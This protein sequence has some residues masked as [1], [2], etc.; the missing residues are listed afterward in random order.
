YVERLKNDFKV[1]TIDIRGN[2]ESDKPIDPAYYTTEK[3]CQDILTV[4]S[5]C[6]LERFIIWGYSYG[7]NIGR[8]FAA[9]S[10]CVSKFVM[11]GFTFGPG[12]SGPFRR[13]I[14]DFSDHWFPILRAQ[15]D[16]SLDLQS[17]SAKDQSLLCRG[18]IPV[19]LAWLSQIL[20]WEAIE[21]GDLLCPTLWF[22]GS[23]N[24][25]VMTDMKEYEAILEATNVRTEVIDGLDHWQEFT[26]IDR[27]LP[28][29][30]SFIQL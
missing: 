22:A 21:P 13:F 28:A 26:E 18:E 19:I 10:R 16:K 24:D 5:A 4:A 27:V 14:T 8:Y 1:I 30:L 23:G 17:L 6:G 15:A 3:H 7:G 12:A 20:D 11:G 2:G 9:Q 25:D 29:V